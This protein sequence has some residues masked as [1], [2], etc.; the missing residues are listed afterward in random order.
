MMAQDIVKSSAWRGSDIQVAI[1]SFSCS[2]SIP[3]LN[4]IPSTTL[5][6]FPKPLR[7]RQRRSAHNPQLE[8]HAQQSPAA[9][10]FS[11]VLRPMADG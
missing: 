8:H 1:W 10:A 3:S 9:Q 6:S 5:P 4:C 11:Q 2:A 7:R